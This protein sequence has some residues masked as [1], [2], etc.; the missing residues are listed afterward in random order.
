MAGFDRAAMQ[1]ASAD[2]RIFAVSDPYVF[3]FYF[4][5]REHA[6]AMLASLRA[7]ETAAAP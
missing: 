2:P 4:L 3:V 6:A 1:R 7:A 5:P